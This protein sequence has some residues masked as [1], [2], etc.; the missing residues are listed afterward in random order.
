MRARRRMT[1]EE[2]TG[3]F[4]A[5]AVQKAHEL[6]KQAGLSMWMAEDDAYNTCVDL[7]MGRI[8]PWRGARDEKHRHA[9]ILTCITRRI[10]N[11]VRN[12][13]TL[14]QSPANR[15]L[16]VDE[17]PHSDFDEDGNEENIETALIQDNGSGAALIRDYEDPTPEPAYAV[18]TRETEKSILNDSHDNDCRKVLRCLKS[19]LTRSAARE[20]SGLSEREFRCKMKKIK[21]R[22]TPCFRA[23]KRFCGKI[24]CTNS[25]KNRDY[26]IE[27]DV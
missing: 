1:Y 20:K 22:F 25:G 24:R 17:A 14:R 6:Y 7:I 13:C 23:Y 10:E 3:K 2:A 4:Y 19:C 5:Y 18:L 12:N 16:S 15:A 9:L 8:K 11:L 26:H 27:G 21:V